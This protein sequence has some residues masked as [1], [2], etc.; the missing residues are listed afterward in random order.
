MASYNNET[1]QKL[2]K[3]FMEF[4][5]I[6]WHNK[7]IAGYNPSEFKV[8]VTIQREANE[9]KTEMKI[10]EI[11]Q[12]LQ[13]TPPTITQIINVLEKDGLVE[14]TID[15]DDRRAVKIKLTPE[16][17][18]VTAKARLAF[19]ETFLGLID[20]LGEE[21]SEQLANLLSKVQQY[22]NQQSHNQE[23]R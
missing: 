16:G 14:R 6:S 22:F 17:L 10:S 5:K 8:L 20:F 15:P 12:F 9:K 11:S 7:K 1:V 3:A 2:L 4:R 18:K 19:S 21:E 23:G 13:V